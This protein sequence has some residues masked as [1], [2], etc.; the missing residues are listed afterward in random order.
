MFLPPENGDVSVKAHTT[1]VMD[2]PNL[3]IF[4]LH[5]SRLTSELEDDGPDLRTPSCADGMPFGQEASI[6]VH[7]DLPFL[8]SLFGFD[9][10]FSL[11]RLCKAQ[12]FLGHHFSNGETIVD[13]RHIDMVRG[14]PRHT[15]GLLRCLLGHNKTSEQLS[16]GQVNACRGSSQSKDPDWFF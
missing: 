16:A 2:Q 9:Q 10:I 14:N 13:L 8:V 3:R 15:I 11:S 6:H 4:D 12:V 5:L 7:R 1:D